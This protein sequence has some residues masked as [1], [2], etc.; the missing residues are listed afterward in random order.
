MS[1]GSSRIGRRLPSVL[2]VPLD[3]E[4]TAGQP[5]WRTWAGHRAWLLRSWA[6]R[7]LGWDRRGTARED[8]Q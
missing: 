1:R 5:S 6:P 3:P 7:L 2:P 8:L 4:A